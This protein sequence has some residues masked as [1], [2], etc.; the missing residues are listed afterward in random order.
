MEDQEKGRTGFAKGGLGRLLNWSVEEVE[1]R[2]RNSLNTRYNRQGRREAGLEIP[3]LEN[4]GA[5]GFLDWR[6]IVM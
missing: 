5:L 3:S 1:L 4:G 2:R 6:E